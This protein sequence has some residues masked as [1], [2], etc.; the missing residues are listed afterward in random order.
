MAAL[1]MEMED[2]S[3]AVLFFFFDVVSVVC[4]VDCVDLVL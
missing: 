4:G 2:G 1:F 3:A